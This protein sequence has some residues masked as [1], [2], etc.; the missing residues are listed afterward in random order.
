MTQK[1]QRTLAEAAK[2][3]SVKVEVSAIF[4]AL[5]H[6]DTLDHLRDAFSMTYGGRPETRQDFVVRVDADLDE[7]DEEFL[8]A[9]LPDEQRERDFA[10]YWIVDDWLA[11]RLAQAGE[12]VVI[13]ASESY[14]WCRSGCGYDLVDDLAF[15]DREADD[16]LD[17]TEYDH[18]KVV[19][20]ED[21]EIRA[22]RSRLDP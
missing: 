21:A 13:L 6:A 9:D 2:Q 3:N 14:C 16:E 5:R 1:N 15:L 17:P 18:A 22:R 8:F 10:Q 4:E 12:V 7:I 19:D 20:C 11:R